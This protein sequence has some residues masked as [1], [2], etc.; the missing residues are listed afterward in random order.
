MTL[1]TVA[2]FLLGIEIGRALFWL[3]MLLKDVPKNIKEMKRVK[4]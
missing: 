2:Y 3:I 4:L 1:E